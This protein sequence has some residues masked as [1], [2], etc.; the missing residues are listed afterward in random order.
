VSFVVEMT[1]QPQP[2][3]DF[4]ARALDRIQKIMLVLGIAGLITA[5]AFFGWRIGVGF[6]L[7]SVIAYLN[8]HWLMKI[9]AGIS[10]LT[11][12]SGTATSRRVVHRFV[13]R[14]VLM[15]VIAFVILA[16]SRESLYGLFAGLFLPAAAILC[17]A[18]YETYKVI[19]G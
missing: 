6:A 1:T 3:D 5:W 7:G 9:V 2:A 18:V 10:E 14:Y 12:V 11:T 17:E 16:V 4:Y 13:L 19:S 8:F 15:A